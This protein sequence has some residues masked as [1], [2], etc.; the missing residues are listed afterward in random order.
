MK[1]HEVTWYSRM[2]AILIFVGVLPTLSFYIG[3][4]YKSFQHVQTLYTESLDYGGGGLTQSL[5]EDTLGEY[6]YR[7]GDGTEFTMRP[8]SDMSI[9]KI[10]PATSAE[11]IPEVTLARQESVSGSH[12]E[13]G[14]IVLY[15]K[16]ETLTLTTNAYK[17]TCLPVKEPDFAPFNFGD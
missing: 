13:G 8:S 6:G 16:G 14:G 9:L 3:M 15:A 2:M 1:W 7:C 12:Y 5:N 11:R 10:F 17:A 4:Q